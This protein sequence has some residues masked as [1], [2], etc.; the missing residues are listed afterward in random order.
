MV[1]SGGKLAG[2]NPE[3][4]RVLNDFYAT[5]PEATDA[6]FDIEIFEGNIWEPACG[7]G[8][9][10]ETIK[11]YNG[12]V[13]SSDLIDRGYGLGGINFLERDSIKRVGLDRCDNIVTNPPFSLFQEFCEMALMV[14]DK[15]IALFGRLQALEGYKRASF[16]ER[17]PLKTVYVFKRRVSI[18]WN[19]ERI[20]NKTGKPWASTLAFAWFVWYKDYSGLPN[21][22]W[23]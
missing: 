21:I 7:N 14:A 13:V 3:R 8:L 12:H 19:G 23:L 6:L 16:L 9:M 1:L 5:S 18:L 15:K 10:S 20:N 17:T 4:G 2:G 11:K 22:R